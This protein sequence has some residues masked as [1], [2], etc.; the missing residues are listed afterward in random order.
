MLVASAS[1]G[2]AAVA[3]AGL[4]LACRHSGHAEL[5]LR[6]P[7]MATSVWALLAATQA[8]FGAGREL[9]ALAET[10][11]DLAWI[12]LL[13]HGIQRLRG[14]ATIDTLGLVGLRRGL[15]ALGAAMLLAQGM[16]LLAPGRLTSHLAYEILPTLLAIA[17]MVLV[18]QYYR[19]SRLQER[20]GIKFLCLALGGLFAY[21]FYLYSEAML[22]A[23]V[24]PDT[25]AARG[26]VNALLV[27]LFWV[28]LRRRPGNRPMAI[29]HRMAFHSVALVGA[30]IYLILMAAAGYYLR[31]VGGNWGA[32]LQTVFLF[33]A[34][35]LLMV[36]VFSGIARARLRVFL[37]KHF[38]HYRYDYR[39]EWLRF[40]SLLT[41]GEP[42]VRVH[43]RSLEAMARLVESP[44]AVLLLKQDDGNFRR[45]AHW[46]WS[47]FHGQLSAEH[48]FVRFLEKRQ[49]IVD[50]H[51]CEEQP[52][53][54]DEAL[55]PAWLAGPS[56]PGWWFP[57]SG[58]TYCSVSWSW[59]TPLA[60]SNSIGKS[61]T[62]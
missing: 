53:L 39:E 3:F 62:F 12:W 8:W 42:G 5:R 50:L 16:A 61:A 21:D 11:R 10:V 52:E 26:A 60:R 44:A 7:A 31:I 23:G 1:Y 22:L 54:L 49:W 32:V 17:G 51:E 18:E 25:W 35:A 56:T 43:E 4:A 14:A 15:F 47:D 57:C 34:A 48:P 46:N 2:L 40:T 55:P 9:V 28:S 37:S 41:E 45:T 30:G 19:N 29:S 6:Y 36:T 20:W 13:W 58:T 24:A 33:G 38:F 59:P 27:P